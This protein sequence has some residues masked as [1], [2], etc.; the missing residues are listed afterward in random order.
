MSPHPLALLAYLVESH[1]LPYPHL[2]SLQHLQ[3]YK[4][5]QLY[6]WPANGMAGCISCV[7]ELT[8]YY[9]ISGEAFDIILSRSLQINISAKVIL[10]QEATAHFLAS[11]LPSLSFPYLT[12][13]SSLS[14]DLSKVM[15][16]S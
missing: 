2:A 8:S 9:P 16:A 4:A 14:H 12:F 15:S 1:H 11:H 13:L 3:R 7:M 5:K 10:P 6:L